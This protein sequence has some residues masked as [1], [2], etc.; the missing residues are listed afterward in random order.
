[1]WE[2]ST[3]TSMSKLWKTTSAALGLFL[4][5]SLSRTGVLRDPGFITFISPEHAS[6]AMRA[7]N[8]EYLDIARSVCITWASWPTKPEVVPLGPPYVCSYSR[9]GADQDYGSGSVTVDLEDP[10]LDVEGPEALVA[11]ARWL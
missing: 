11:E 7:M 4:R 6:D 3:S 2:G 8:G 5:W 10:D 9:V 1:M